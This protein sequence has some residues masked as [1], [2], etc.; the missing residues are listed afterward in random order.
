MTRSWLGFGLLALLLVLSLLSTCFLA[1]S[2]EEVILD[3]KQ[4]SQCALLGDW[5]E[6]QLFSRQARDRWDRWQHLRAC[7]S[8]HSPAEEID[9]AFAELDIYRQA[10]EATPYRAACAVLISRLEAFSAAQ[11]PLWWNLF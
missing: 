11:S 5:E 8:D 4:A 6:V 2:Q 9:S 1:R 3:L 7:L 10:R